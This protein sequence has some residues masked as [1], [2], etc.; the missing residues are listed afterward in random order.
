MT[1]IV[2]LMSAATMLVSAWMTVMYFVLR[3]PGYAW[4]A[5]ISAVICLGAATLLAGR[6]AAA[7][8][9]PTAVWGAALAAFGIWALVATGDDGWVIVAGALFVV[10]GSLAVYGSRP[11][12]PT[13]SL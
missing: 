1:T 3:H 13:A 6:P 8:R 5:A 11:R 12:R 9:I 4:R 7:L 2:G 10:E